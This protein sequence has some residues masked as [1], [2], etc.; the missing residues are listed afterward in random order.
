MG[1]FCNLDLGLDHTAHSRVS[2]INLYLRTKFCS[3][4]DN[5]VWTYAGLE[6]SDG[7]GKGLNPRPQFMSTDAHF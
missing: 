6:L 3:N 2:L 4:R 7:R 5:F 1:H